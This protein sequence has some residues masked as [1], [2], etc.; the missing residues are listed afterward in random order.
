MQLRQ[1]QADVTLLKGR[2]AKM[3]LDNTMMGLVNDEI[4]P[5]M[6]AFMEATI[7]EVK[8]IRSEAK[9]MK[10]DFEELEDVAFAHLEGSDD[11]ITPETSAQLIETFEL[12]LMVCGILQ[13]VE[14]KLDNDLAN[15]KLH[16]T[17][18]EYQ[19]N[20]L[21]LVKLVL[22][23]TVE[24]DEDEDGEVDDDL[25]TDE[26][27]EVTPLEIPTPRTEKV[28]ND[29]DANGNDGNDGNDTTKKAAKK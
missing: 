8:A 10:A 4:L 27:E 12:G 22:E 21:A 6:E 1:I 23:S 5:T 7:E 20:S 16:D 25:P 11:V 17:I 28:N 13:E 18:T 2:V 24:D 19:R 3:A 9:E 29:D 14:L 15:K 26:D